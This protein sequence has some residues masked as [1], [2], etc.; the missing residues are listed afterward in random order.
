MLFKI[1]PLSLILALGIGLYYGVA[2]ANS[3]TDATLDRC[4]SASRNTKWKTIS[5]RVR[6]LCKTNQWW[7]QNDYRGS[8]VDYK[9]RASKNR[10]ELSVD[11]AFRY[12][13][14]PENRAVVTQRLQAVELCVAQ[15]Y[16][17]FG[18]HL[19]PNFRVDP[20]QQTLPL[21]LL[22]KS[23]ISLWDEYD[24][25]GSANWPLLRSNGF[26]ISEDQACLI[27]T[28]ELGHKLGLPDRYSES[29]CPDRERPREPTESEDSIM[30]AGIW[31]RTDEKVLYPDD[32]EIILSPICPQH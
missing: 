9:I 2:T 25:A 8:D 11:L 26:E 13:G 27:A 23:E 18:L 4:L 5:Y 3:E 12:K 31:S 19:T 22:E 7:Q 16:A 10:I 15:F 32:L 30:G 1:L 21:S 29:K 24:R 14:K 17:R 6:H 28:H 20:E